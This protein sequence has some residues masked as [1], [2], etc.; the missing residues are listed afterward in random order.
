MKCM[1]PSIYVISS[2][3]SLSLSSCSPQVEALQAA[4]DRERKTSGELRAQLRSSSAPAA[5]AAAAEAQQ[6][7]DE[8]D[9]IAPPGADKKFTSYLRRVNNTRR[10]NLETIRQLRLELDAMKQDPVR[11]EAKRMKSVIA[12][13]KAEVASLR[14]ENARKA[15]LLSTFRSTRASDVS[16][17]DQWRHEAEELEEKIK[18]LKSSLASKDALIKELKAKIDAIESSANDGLDGGDAAAGDDYKALSQAE[19]KNRCVCGVDI[20]GS[21]THGS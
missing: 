16:A 13:L 20:Q 6:G 15:K 11:E 21:P 7:L 18:R 5:S 14:E 9:I 12:E 10:S 1:H 17:V 4:L 19:L 8:G 3:L 2:S